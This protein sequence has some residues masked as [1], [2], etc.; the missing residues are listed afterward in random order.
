MT[1]TML[2]PGMIHSTIE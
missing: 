1:T 2:A